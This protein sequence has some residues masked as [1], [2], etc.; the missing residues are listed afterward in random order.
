MEI[1]F[2]ILTA[3]QCNKIK[4]R[5]DLLVITDVS[6]APKASLISLEKKI[7]FE[8]AQSGFCR[9]VGNT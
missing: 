3:R 9:S 6:E 7:K 5:T 2:L 1:K 8:G 4:G